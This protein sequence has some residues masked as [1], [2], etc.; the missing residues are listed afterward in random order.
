MKSITKGF[1]DVDFVSSDVEGAFR[2]CL[3]ARLNTN[4][5]SS[6]IAIDVLFCPSFC[7][8]LSLDL[9][10]LAGGEVV[11]SKACFFTGFVLTFGGEGVV[12]GESGYSFVCASFRLP[13]VVVVMLVDLRLLIV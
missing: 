3:D 8:I 13:V 2:F 6:S 9:L 10:R 11:K 7:A 12:G 1:E 5:S 4:P